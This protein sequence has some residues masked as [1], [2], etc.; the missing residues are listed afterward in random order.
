MGDLQNRLIDFQNESRT[1]YDDIMKILE[2]KYCW[3]CPMRSTS[4]KSRCREIHSGR[5][6]QEAFDEGILTHLLEVD[7]DQ[8]EVEALI[9]RILKKKIKRAGGNQRE[10]TIMMKLDAEQNIDRWLKIK[11]NPR[12]LKIGDK[13]LVSDKA[14]NH[15]LLGSYA[16]VAGFPFH[17][18]SVKRIFHEGNFWY[19]EIENDEIFPLDSIFGVMIGI[20]EEDYMSIEEEIDVF[21]LKIVAMLPDCTLKEVS[22]LFLEKIKQILKSESGYVAFIDP[23]NRDSVGVSFSHLTESCQMYEE[24]GEARFKVLNDGSYGGLLGYSLDTGKSF[25]VHDISSHSAAHGLPPGHDPVNQFLSVPV[26]WKDQILGQIV[27]GNPKEDYNQ[28]HVKIAEKIASIYAL[29]LKIL[30]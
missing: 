12:H 26:K 30:L 19:V 1:A 13:V 3:K 22:D 11:I 6:L 27:V 14:K 7:I 29:V 18:A 9:N 8:V 17:A 25:Y 23:E 24:I 20:F 10:T 15:S 2:D 5:V 28:N 16:L 4:D 21:S